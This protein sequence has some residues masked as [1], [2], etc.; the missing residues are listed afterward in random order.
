MRKQTK[1]SMP[2]EWGTRSR[3]VGAEVATN[4]DKLGRRVWMTGNINDAKLK[5]F[6]QFDQ[7]RLLLPLN[8]NYHYEVA[9]NEKGEFVA[10][11]R[12]GQT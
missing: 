6:E 9:L 2:D 10:Q 1:I 4:V 5:D 3:T 12:K 8:D 11:I 7:M